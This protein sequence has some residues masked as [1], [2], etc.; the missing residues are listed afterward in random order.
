MRATACMSSASRNVGPRRD[1]PCR[2]IGVAMWTNGRGTNSVNPPVSACR[3]R[4]RSRCRAHDTGCSMAPNMMVM[5][6]RSPMEW[7]TR[8][9]SSHSSVSILS[10]QRTARTPSSRISA[11]VP[12]RVARPA[13]FSRPR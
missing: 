3:A 8:W 7:A 13:A 12:G 2:N 6:D 1:L 5:F 11:A 4:V 9:A 10:G